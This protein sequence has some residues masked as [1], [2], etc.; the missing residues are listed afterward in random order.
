[1]AKAKT[2]PREDLPPPDS[3]PI[4]PGD[5]RFGQTSQTYDGEADVA[6]IAKYNNM[7]RV[8]LQHGLAWPPGSE[9]VEPVPLPHLESL[10]PQ[11][12]VLDS[13]D[14]VVSVLGS[15]FTDDAK[16][17]FAGV[18]QPTTFVDVNNLTVEVSPVDVEQAGDVAV[19]VR[20][21][22]GDSNSKT[23]TFTEPVAPPAPPPQQA[24]T[25]PAPQPAPMAAKTATVTK[26]TTVTAGKA[27]K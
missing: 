19:I 15:Y 12:I 26:T 4:T 27:K 5:E 16:V 11:E 17:L 10:S 7:R 8:Y 3:G 20:C 2:T 1:M 9:N 23:L 25:Q 6:A 22:T 21:E 24:Q 13:P 14:L 18:E